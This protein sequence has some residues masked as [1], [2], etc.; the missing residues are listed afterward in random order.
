MLNVRSKR[1]STGLTLENQA[2]YDLIKAKLNI[3]ASGCVPGNPD[4]LTYVPTSSCTC[5]YLYIYYFMPLNNL[6]QNACHMH[7]FE[8]RSKP[9][10]MH[11]TQLNFLVASK[12]HFFIT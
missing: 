5:K 8:T 2:K 4:Y 10:L 11:L 3:P 6:F 1:H 9:K 12:I 7:T